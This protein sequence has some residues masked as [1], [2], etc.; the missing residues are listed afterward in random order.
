MAD[1]DFLNQP[2]YVRDRRTNTLLTHVSSKNKTVSTCP[3]NNFSIDLDSSELNNIVGIIINR[4]FIPNVIDNITTGCN[5]VQIELSD[6]TL[7]NIA[8]PNGFYDIL[9]LADFIEAAFNVIIGPE[10]LSFVFNSNTSVITWT[11][12]GGPRTF[13]FNVSPTSGTRDIARDKM[14][15]NTGDAFGAQKIGTDKVD[16]YPRTQSLFIELNFAKANYVLP[17]FN[18]RSILIDIPVL[19][20]FGSIIS[21]KDS[22]DKEN[23][24]D[25]QTP[26]SIDTLQIRVLDDNQNEVT[27]LA[28]FD[29]HMTLVFLK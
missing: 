25:L 4:V 29:W 14:K 13:R 8:I 16:L 6:T 26:T 24:I 2:I 18:E 9:S 11:I 19:G 17:N 12:A 22:G 7:V 21:Y 10:V 23:I 28:N 20:P 5:Q 15:M 3:S 1:K 27:E